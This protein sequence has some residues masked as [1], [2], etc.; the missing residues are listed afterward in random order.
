M[1]NGA[2]IN[3]AFEH[4]P[5]SPMQFAEMVPLQFNGKSLDLN[6][7][8][9]NAQRTVDSF[10]GNA[11]D[12]LADNTGIADNTKYRPTTTDAAHELRQFGEAKALSQPDAK[13]EMMEWKDIQT[14][15][16][17]KDA[18][19]NLPDRNHPYVESA[20]VLPGPPPYCADAYKYYTDE[21][22]RAVCE[23][24]HNNGGNGDPDYW[25]NVS[26]TIAMRLPNGDR[27]NATYRFD[28]NGNVIG[29]DLGVVRPTIP[30]SGYSVKNVPFERFPAL[31]QKVDQI[32]DGL[33]QPKS[34][35]V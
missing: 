6:Q 31:L 2:E 9:I 18:A 24:V 29:A 33:D 23:H 19:G 26:A 5:A 22:G 15:A 8:N 16:R 28:L 35:S 13:G 21:H 1:G 25:V 34:R 20:A 3:V 17:T 7:K 10:F 14:K 27:G 30:P 11:N 32:E 4:E 12:L